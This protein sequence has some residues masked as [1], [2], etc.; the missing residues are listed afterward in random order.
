MTHKIL[1]QFLATAAL[2][3][4]VFM[5]VASVADAQDKTSVT[6]ALPVNLCLANWP[7]YVAAEKGLFAEENLEVTMQ[8]VDGSSAAIQAMLAG[9]AQV[10]ATAPADFLTASGAGAKMTGFYSFYQY[11]PFRIVTTEGSKIKSVADLAGKTVGISSA[12]GGDAIYMRS[13]LSFSGVKEGS[14]EEL[15]VGEGN[16]AASAL[17]GGTVDAYSASFVEEIIF[18]GMNIAYAPLSADGYPATTGEL[19]ATQ[20]SYFEENPKVIEGLGRA[21]ARATKAG[22]ADRELIVSVCGKAAPQETEDKGFTTAVLDGVAPLFTL[23]DATGG[24]PGFIDET[25]WAKYRDL[26]VSIGVAGPAAATAGISNAHTS[27]W[28]K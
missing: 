13:L 19:L 22:L 16:T 15:A 11:L 17:T 2:A 27:A 3:S 9:Q 1:T 18:K 6:V 20:T 4:T 14:Y 23:T 7:F 21:L 12:A 24:K 26:M 5:A 28:S 25:E 10:A 8:G